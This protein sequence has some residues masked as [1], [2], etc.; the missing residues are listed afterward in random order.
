[1]QRLLHGRLLYLIFGAFV[2]FLYVRT[3]PLRPEISPETTKA[4]H[5]EHAMEWWPSDFDTAAFEQALAREPATAITLLVLTAF[6]VG[7]GVG[8]FALTLRAF[9]SGRIRDL[10]RFTPPHGAGLPAWTFG[11]LGRIT[12]LTVMVALLLP[13]AHLSLFFRDSNGRPDTH[14]W[15]TLSMCVLDLFVIVAILAFASGKRSSPW[16]TFG[17]SRGGLSARIATSFRAYLA[18]FPWIFLL[19][20]LAVE[21]VR[22]IGL[23]PPVEPIQRLIFQEHRPAVLVLTAVLACG[24]GPLAEELFFRGV[25]YTAIRQRT[26]RVVA[27]LA[28]SAAFSL[29]HT[30][31]VGFLPIMALGCLLAY[32]YERT[33]SL[34]SSLAVHIAHNTLLLSLALILRR[35]MTI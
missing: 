2:A 9:G 29:L 6:M 1:M 17:V 35:L 22:A 7:M 20:F 26:P 11:E 15:L 16:K 12:L 34:I 24:I 5:A 31:L 25:V 19:L 23:K 18:V 27:I 4:P 30:N 13:F 32:L 28:S 8:G 14:L 33:G 10:W 21:G 3:F